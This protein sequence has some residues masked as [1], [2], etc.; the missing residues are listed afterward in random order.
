ML[1]N[2]VLQQSIEFFLCRFESEILGHT[3]GQPP[4]GARGNL[5][6][7]PF[8]PLS[9]RNF[10]N[11]LDERPRGRDVVQR[12]VTIK[13]VQ[14]E[15]ALHLRMDKQRL[16][17]RAEEEILSEAREVQWLVD[18]TVPGKNKPSF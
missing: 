13:A 10:F 14:T 2:G 11:A 16:E 3:K 8:Q 18:H 5:A 7:I 12:E 6:V 1:S 4:I 17:L 15:P 9:R